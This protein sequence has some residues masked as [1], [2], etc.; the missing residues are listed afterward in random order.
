MMWLFYFVILND[1]VS[2]LFQE[3]EGR[4]GGAREDIT[5]VTHRQVTARTHQ[6]EE[7]FGVNQGLIYYLHFYF[8]LL[9]YSFPLHSNYFTK[10]T[11]TKKKLGTRWVWGNKKR[12]T[13]S[14]WRLW[15]M[16]VRKG[17]EI[18]ENKNCGIMASLLFS[19][20]LLS[21]CWV[22]NVIEL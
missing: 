12:W 3:E 2:V 21:S 20:I 7:A 4:G 22:Q 8:V 10:K 1:P 14:R 11:T 6:W 19:T 13:E 5:A 18:K 15:I 9:N 17:K 16:G